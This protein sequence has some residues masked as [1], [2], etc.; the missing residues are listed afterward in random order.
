MR[1]RNSVSQ[2]AEFGVVEV[3]FT[4]RIKPNMRM[5]S[6]MRT[7]KIHTF[8]DLFCKYTGEYVD[9]VFEFTP[10]K[11]LDVDSSDLYYVPSDSAIRRLLTAKY[12]HLLNAVPMDDLVMVIS[13]RSR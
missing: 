9:T 11:F 4:Y 6:G 8:I 13:A 2:F 12:L 10:Q 5:F 1:R 3:E 7:N